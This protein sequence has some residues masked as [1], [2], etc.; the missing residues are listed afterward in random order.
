MGYDHKYVYGHF[1]YNL[2]ATDLQASVGC[3][4]IEKLPGFVKQRKAN[5][6]YLR[7]KLSDVKNKLI[8]PDPAENADPSWFGF[9]MCCTP[10]IDRNK[11][12]QGIEKANIQ[13]RMLFAGNIIKHPC[14]DQ[15]RKNERGYRVVGDLSNT[16]YVMNNGFWIGVYPG[17]TEPMLDKMIEV[18]REIIK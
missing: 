11:L 2:K 13:T 12:V 9:M 4:Q 3:A 7:E 15:L 17:M 5:W 10:G 14:F 1:G 8:L 6:K 16:D 18:I